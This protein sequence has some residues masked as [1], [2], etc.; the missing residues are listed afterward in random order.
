MHNDLKSNAIHQST[1][2][3]H[4][5][6]MTYSFWL[7]SWIFNQ[8]QRFAFASGK[9]LDFEVSWSPDA[10]TTGLQ[11]CI[12]RVILAGDWIKISY[13]GAQDMLQM[14]VMLFPPKNE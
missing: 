14:A 4:S 1:T 11:T 7:T 3:S 9:C 6:C 13:F 5:V 2:F 12:I 8:N 10:I